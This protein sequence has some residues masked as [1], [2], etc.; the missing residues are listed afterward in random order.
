MSKALLEHLVFLDGA[1]RAPALEQRLRALLE[2]WSP[3]LPPA[4]APR[5]PLA[6][7]PADV[8]LIT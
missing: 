7:T 1:T 4:R 2:R 8:V 5:G 6:L 3:A